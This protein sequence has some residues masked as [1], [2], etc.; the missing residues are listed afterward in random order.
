M[1]TVQ[2]AGLWFFY[3]P[4][5]SD[6]NTLA[7]CCQFDEYGLGTEDV[8]GKLV[9]DV[10][11][12]IGGVSVWLSTR[13]ATV[14]AIEPIP[15]NAELVRRNAALNDVPVITREGAFGTSTIAFGADEDSD[16]NTVVHQW[17]GHPDQ[18]EQDVRAIDVEQLSLT[19]LVREYGLPSIIKTDC[20]GGEWA[21][22]SDEAAKTV[23]L[24]VGEWHPRGEYRGQVD[25]VALLG[26]THDVTFSGPEGGPGGFTARRR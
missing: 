17:I 23:P 5:T 6:Y 9:F 24:I 3:R 14:V 8:S 25:V 10:G 11:A 1:R 26:E 21:L 15:E 13:G 7:A 16:E 4:E 19:D 22:L 20:E 18:G 2:L 12:H